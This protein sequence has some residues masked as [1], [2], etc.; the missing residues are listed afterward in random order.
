[1][2]TSLT[3]FG[4]R[5]RYA[6]KTINNFSTIQVA[7]HAGLT[8]M[9]ISDWEKREEATVTASKLK[10]VCDYYGV[11][12]EWIVSGTGPITKDELDAITQKELA[13][14]QINDVQ[15][16]L[17]GKLTPAQYR[18]VA[19]ASY[20]QSGPRDFLIEID[21]DY[22]VEFHKGDTIICN[23]DLPAE[24]T[25]YILYKSGRSTI[26]ASYVELPGNR[27]HISSLDGSSLEQYQADHYIATI[28]GKW[29]QMKK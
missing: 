21:K 7:D 29:L 3:R 26:I 22:S 5:M 20:I 23:P 27:R 28:C 9:T 8:R 19:V 14:L 2:T 18:S 10:T 6:R 12:L 1:M 11:N 15:A 17:S 13:V 24:N 4:D 16:Y 25:A